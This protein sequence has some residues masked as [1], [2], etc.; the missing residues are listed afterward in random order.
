M[1]G[2]DVD[3]RGTIV[4]GRGVVGGQSVTVPDTTVLHLDANE[5]TA[6]DGDSLTTWP[7]ISGNANDVTGGS[8]TYVENVRD[9]NPVVRFNGSSDTL[10][11]YPTSYSQP[12]TIMVAFNPNID[13]NQHSVFATSSSGTPRGHWTIDGSQWWTFSNGSGSTTGGSPNDAWMIA[14]AIIDGSNTV[15]RVNGVDDFNTSIGTSNWGGFRV[16]EHY[17]NHSYMDGDY[18][19]IVFVPERLTSTE[20]QEQEDRLARNWNVTL[21]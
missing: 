17:Q 2:I 15:V 16:G 1:R 20:L 9:G 18:G 13:G 12:V 4:N 5:I 7:D 10:S 21:E 19:E 8:P 14:T 6:T 3:G 11:A